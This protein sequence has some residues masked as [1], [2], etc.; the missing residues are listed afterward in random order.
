MQ[1]LAEEIAQGLAVPVDGWDFSW[2]AGRATEERPPWGYVRVLAERLS[3]AGSVLDLQT[4]GGEVLAEALARA[5]VVPVNL[6]ATEAWEPNAA[7]ASR[8]LEPFGGT[9]AATLPEDPLPFDDASFDLVSAR[10]PVAVPWS[11]VARVLRPG[12]VFLGQ[13]VGRGT[14]RALFEYFLGPQPDTDAAFLDD[15][16]TD[17]R[18]AGLEV[19]RLE[20][21]RTRVE[22]LDLASVVH[23]LRKVLW[24]VPGFTVEEHED[25]LR[26]LYEHIREHGSFVSYS[27][28]TLLEARVAS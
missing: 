22:F 26:D 7:I 24:T 17:T 6:A 9:V 8:N 14:N 10:H 4:G 21:T 18:E 5:G 16:R 1:A 19:L 2:F 12:G 20:D 11:E 23:F 3:G 13:L 27:R 15:V 25:R 28:R